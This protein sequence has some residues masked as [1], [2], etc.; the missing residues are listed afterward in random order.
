MVKLAGD[1]PIA[2]AEV[3]KLPSPEV[4]DR[5]PR[6]TYFMD[7]SEFIQDANTQ[8]HAKVLYNAPRVLTRDDPRL[9][10]PMAAIRK[11]TAEHNGGTISAGIKTAR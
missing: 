3:G 7:W 9:A 11:T 5:Q 10:V 4:L 1:K 2:L 6:W 8:E